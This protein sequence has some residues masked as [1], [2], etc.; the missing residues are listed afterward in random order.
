MLVVNADIIDSLLSVSRFRLALAIAAHTNRFVGEIFCRSSF[1][2]VQMQSTHELIAGE[3]HTVDDD[4][5][6]A[7]K[8]NIRQQLILDASVAVV[9]VTVDAVLFMLCILGEILRR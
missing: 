6:L 3:A 8:Q 7:R 4:V 5:A 9:D 1:A 2:C